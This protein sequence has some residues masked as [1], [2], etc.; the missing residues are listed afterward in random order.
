MF[1]CSDVQVCI[2]GVPACKRTCLNM[3]EIYL[4]FCLSTVFYFFQAHFTSCPTCNIFH[5]P[6]NL[7]RIISDIKPMKE[8]P[9]FDQYID[10]YKP[11][12]SLVETIKKVVNQ[13]RI[14]M[15]CCFKNIDIFIISFGHFI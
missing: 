5:H 3:H 4:L 1:A 7:A 13:W 10:Q 8:C 12:F 15:E 11:I 2:C 9:H 14:C 6:L